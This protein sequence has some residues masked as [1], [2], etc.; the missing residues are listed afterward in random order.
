MTLALS[1]R[2]VEAV[3]ASRVCLR[4][5][6]RSLAGLPGSGLNIAVANNLFGKAELCARLAVA[7]TDV[8]HDVL[9]IRRASLRLPARIDR[10]GGSKYKPR[11]AGAT[12]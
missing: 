6:Q 3:S 9:Q 1:P 5:S 11:N 10:E 12:L 4:G 8:T 2:P 7:M